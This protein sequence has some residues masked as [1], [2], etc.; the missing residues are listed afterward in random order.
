MTNFVEV[1]LCSSLHICKYAGLV[2][3]SK[4]FGQI[5]TAN[6]VL[7]VSRICNKHKCHWSVSEIEVAGILYAILANSQQF[8]RPSFQNVGLH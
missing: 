4:Q 7:Y 5:V 8:N 3:V 1:V 2:S 6:N